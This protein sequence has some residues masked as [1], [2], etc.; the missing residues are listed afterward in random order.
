MNNALTTIVLNSS[1]SRASVMVM[2]FPLFQTRTGRFSLPGTGEPRAVSQRKSSCC[3]P[4]SQPS[5][6]YAAGGPR[7]E[8]AFLLEPGRRRVAHVG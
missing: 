6:F 3:A 7:A 2:S 5:A 1:F 4:L 8:T